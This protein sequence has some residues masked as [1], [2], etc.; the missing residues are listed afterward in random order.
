MRCH[1]VLADTISLL[2]SISKLNALTQNFNPLVEPEILNKDLHR[3]VHN[4]ASSRECNKWQ[5]EFQKEC[6]RCCT[7]ILKSILAG[8]RI[9]VL[10]IPY[11]SWFAESKLNALAQN[12]KPAVETEVQSRRLYKTVDHATPSRE[13]VNSQT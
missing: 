12:F 2:D 4:A 6:E 8:G 5:A 1:D 13:R 7:L 11:A 9:M 3:A 10:L